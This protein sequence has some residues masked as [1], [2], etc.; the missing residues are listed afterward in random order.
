MQRSPK[1][2]AMTGKDALHISSKQELRAW[3][4][5]ASDADLDDYI[6][7]VSAVHNFWT[8]ADPK[9]AMDQQIHFMKNVAIM[10][11]MLFIIANGAGDAGTRGRSLEDSSPRYHPQGAQPTEQHQYSIQGAGDR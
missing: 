9:E 1:N 7:G 11:A 10:G 3:L 4:R 6:N 8:Y 5:A 2:A